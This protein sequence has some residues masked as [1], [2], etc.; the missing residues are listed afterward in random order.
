VRTAVKIERRGQSEPRDRELCKRWL[1]MELS[2]APEG[3]EASVKR[4]VRGC[5]VVRGKL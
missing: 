3:E 4:G 1:V 5:R 2:G